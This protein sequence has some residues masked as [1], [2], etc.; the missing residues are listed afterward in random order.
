[1]AVTMLHAKFLCAQGGF[2]RGTT[3]LP[4][5]A[6]LPAASPP[7]LSCGIPAPPRAL[8]GAKPPRWQRHVHRTRLPQGVGSPRGGGSR[9]PSP[10]WARAAGSIWLRSPAPGAGRAGGEGRGDTRAPSG[11]VPLGELQPFAGD[12]RGRMGP[13]ASQSSRRSGAAGGLAA[14]QTHGVSSRSRPICTKIA[15]LTSIPALQQGNCS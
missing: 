12:E 9:S 11:Q 3:A 7:R 10:P 8:G 2:G 6:L 5:Q 14:R 15:V 13:G 4:T 1:M